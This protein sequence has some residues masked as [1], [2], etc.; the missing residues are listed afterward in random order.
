MR[1]GRGASNLADVLMLEYRLSQAC[2]A[3][4]DYYEG[5]RAVLIDKDHA[6]S[7]RP[8][9]LGDVGSDIVEA[10]FIA[11]AHGDWTVA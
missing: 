10:H 9:T 2:M 4:H 1:R 6:P 5:I 7:W 11:P 8:A 3:G